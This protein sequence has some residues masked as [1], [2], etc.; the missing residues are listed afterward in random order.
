MGFRA[1]LCLDHANFRLVQ[2][3]DELEDSDKD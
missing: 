3:S 2:V 1:P